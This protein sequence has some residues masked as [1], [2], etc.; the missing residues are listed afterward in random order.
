M[1]ADPFFYP[2]VHDPMSE[3][4]V[5]IDNDLVW[6]GVKRPFHEVYHVQINDTN[7]RWGFSAELALNHP[8]DF[9]DPGTS[10]VTACFQERGLEAVQ[11]RQDYDLSTHDVVHADEFIHIDKSSLSLAEC[12]G[13]VTVEK[14]T[15]KWELV[16]EDPVLSFRPCPWNF[17]FPPRMVPARVFVP[18]VIGFVSGN[19]YVDHRKFSFTRAR[20]SQSH[21]HGSRL[22][23]QLTRVSCLSFVEDPEAFFEGQTCV[24]RTQKR[25]FGPLTLGCMG[26]EGKL[27]PFNSLWRVLTV[28]RS[29]TNE[30]AW[31]ARYRHSGYEFLC[32]VQGLEEPV[33]RQSRGPTGETGRI[34]RFLLADAEIEVRRKHRGRWQDYKLL[35]APKRAFFETLLTRS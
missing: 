5:K 31:N 21:H 10:S 12:T 32:R 14:Q 25:R 28:N 33:M 1:Q 35:T 22:P 26:L 7:G 16:F 29:T 20:V 24:L 15:I 8:E 9:S 4:L 30:V 18:R 2:G 34:R 3:S 27:Y 13:G 17:I 19:I 23:D 11:L 6:D